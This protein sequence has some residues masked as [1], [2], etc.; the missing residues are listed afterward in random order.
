M[1]RL[2]AKMLLFFPAYTVSFHLPSLTVV[3][4]V[5]SRLWAWM[6]PYSFTPPRSA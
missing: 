5:L 4:S 2:A 3:L 6:C 1:S